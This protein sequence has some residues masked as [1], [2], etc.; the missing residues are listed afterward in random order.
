[1]R[2]KVTLNGETEVVTDSYKHAV[3]VYHKAVYHGKP[4]DIIRM[5]F[6]RNPQD[7]WETIRK[8]WL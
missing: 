8:D 1:M 6:R 2:Y 3:A 5:Y 4:N 7:D